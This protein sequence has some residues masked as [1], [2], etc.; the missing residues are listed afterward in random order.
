MVSK[1]NK[2]FK[3]RCRVKNCTVNGE[4]HATESTVCTSL[5]PFSW[6]LNEHKLRGVKSSVTLEYSK[7]ETELGLGE[8]VFC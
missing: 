4:G 8:L 3:T 2:Y 6:Q 5:I 7:P 1:L